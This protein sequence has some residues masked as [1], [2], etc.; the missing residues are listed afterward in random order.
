MNSRDGRLQSEWTRFA[1]KCPR[2]KWQ[3]LGNLSLIPKSSIL[4]FKHHQIAAFIETSVTS[5]IMKK[6]QRDERSCFSR[7]RRHQEP[8]EASK[9]DSLGAEICPHE[10]FAMSCSVPFI[11]DEIDHSQHCVQPLWHILSVGHQIWNAGIANFAFCSHE[12][13]RHGR[14]GHEKRARDLVCLE[15]TQST[16]CQSHLCFRS[17]CGVAASENQPKTVVGNFISFVVRFLD[18]WDQTARNLS[19]NFL[20][21]ARLASETVKGFVPS[22]LDDPCGR[23]IGDT[24]FTPLVN[25]C[26]KG[27]LRRLFG[28]VK[29]TK[30]PDQ[31]G[32]DTAPVRAI[33]RLDCGIGFQ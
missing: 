29:I 21:K 13:L 33:D 15:A 25:G 24:S 32:D 23:R 16:Q 5:R 28:Y 10:R 8:Q 9:A 12:P 14:G 7:R 4:F 1:A 31:R 19:F 20:F 17:K 2:Y 18:G 11:K 30:R 6:H 26:G 3:R 22:R 27:L